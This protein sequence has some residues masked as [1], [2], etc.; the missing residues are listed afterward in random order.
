MPH[1]KPELMKDATQEELKKETEKWLKRLEEATKEIKPTGKLDEKILNDLLKNMR[2]YISDCYHFM[3]KSEWVRAFEAVIY[4]W[5]I[6]ESCLHLKLI[7][8]KT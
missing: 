2:A 5:G 3:E 1:E 8:K 7:E 4:A 6:Y